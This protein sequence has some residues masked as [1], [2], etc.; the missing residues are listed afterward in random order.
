MVVDTQLFDLQ[1]VPVLMLAEKDRTRCQ[2]TRCLQR[3]YLSPISS[4]ATS[5]RCI[6]F[7][8]ASTGCR[9]TFACTFNVVT[10]ILQEGEESRSSQLPV[11]KI[12][13]EGFLLA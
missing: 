13:A 1:L 5:S 8:I 11:A 7:S 4:V 3:V 6:R 2:I 10:L 9:L 12:A